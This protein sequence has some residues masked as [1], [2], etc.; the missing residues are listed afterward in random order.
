MAVV[1]VPIGEVLGGWQDLGG[2]AEEVTE[3]SPPEGSRGHLPPHRLG[4]WLEV[5]SEELASGAYEVVKL[6]H[7]SLLLLYPNLVMVID[8]W[9]GNVSSIRVRMVDWHPLLDVVFFR[10]PDDVQ[11]AEVGHGEACFR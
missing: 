11:L 7:L 6:P 2:L 5:G 8:H 4:P 3:H 1:A 10:P 9:Q